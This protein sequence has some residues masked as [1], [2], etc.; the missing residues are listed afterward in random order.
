MWGP[1]IGIPAGCVDI[2]SAINERSA[3]VLSGRGSL[4]IAKIRSYTRRPRWRQV[5]MKKSGKRRGVDPMSNLIII[6]PQT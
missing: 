3:S 5:I 1:N 2:L 6:K 4:S